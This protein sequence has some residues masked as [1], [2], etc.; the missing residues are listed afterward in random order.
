MK[1]P[2]RHSFDSPELGSY[3]CVVEGPHT[4][5]LT[6][7]EP[8]RWW[9]SYSSEPQMRLPS[10][11]MIAVQ[12]LAGANSTAKRLAL[13]DA[14]AER[15]GETEGKAHLLRKALVRAMA[16]SHHANQCRFRYGELCN[17]W[18]M[19]AQAALDATREKS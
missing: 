15:L 1:C 17:C 4:R 14:I 3:G 10:G 5:H 18:R 7:E 19:Q 8:A 11:A 12:V 9:E 2:E 13:V 16:E 6:G